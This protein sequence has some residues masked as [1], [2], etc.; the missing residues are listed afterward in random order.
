MVLSGTCRR[1]GCNVDKGGALINGYV[2][3]TVEMVWKSWIDGNERHIHGINIG[4][5][6]YLNQD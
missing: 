5:S 6:L 3:E 4:V 1:C 2:V